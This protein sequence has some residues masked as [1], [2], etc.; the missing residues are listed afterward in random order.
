[1][2][3]PPDRTPQA[4]PAPH[5]K[6]KRMRK[7]PPRLIL[8]FVALGIIVLV[9]AIVAVMKATAPSPPTKEPVTFIPSVEVKKL[10]SGNHRLEVNTQGEVAPRTQ[11]NL[12]AEVSGQVIEVSPSMEPGGA[13]KKGDVLFQIDPRNYEAALIAAEADLARAKADLTRQQAESEQAQRDWETLGNGGTPSALVL[14]EPQLAQARAA[15]SSAQAA[16]QKA[17]TDLE[18]TSITAPYDGRSLIK[19]AEIGGFVNNFSGQLGTIFA[20]DYAEVRLPLSDAQLAKLDST[21][22]QSGSG[23]IDNG[24]DVTLSG[25]TA[26]VERSWQARITRMEA[27][28]DATSRLYY[29]IARVDR[30]YSPELHE[31]PLLIGLFVNAR[32][33]GRI[34]ENTIAIPRVAL[35]PNDRVHVVTRNNQLDIRPVKVAADLGDRIIIE[36]GLQSGDL[37]C[38]T[39]LNSPYS[40]M[41][42]SLTEAGPEIPEAGPTQIGGP[43]GESLP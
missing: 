17:R 37:I 34:A 10:Q 35:H 8:I 23:I 7:S 29:A 32:I 15:L 43:E 40:G 21:L 25:K 11:T 14:R 39:P 16:V 28:V 38:I 30:P 31:S 4:D 12:V 5:K 26:G 24:P 13:F 9:I 36:S 2:P 19:N 33:S 6:A 18:R 20:T 41:D 27:A 22:L 42:V 1:M 3:P